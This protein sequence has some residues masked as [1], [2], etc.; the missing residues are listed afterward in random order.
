VN[1]ASSNDRAVFTLV[2]IDKFSLL[3]YPSD[4]IGA[5]EGGPG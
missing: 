1:N 5:T 2:A 4:L 3:E